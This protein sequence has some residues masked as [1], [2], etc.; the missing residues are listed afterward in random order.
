M[1][2]RLI[3]IFSF[4]ILIMSLIIAPKVEAFDPG[5]ITIE[6][7]TLSITCFRYVDDGIEIIIDGGVKDIIFE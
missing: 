5:D 4:V 6:C 3:G 2:N 7:G 1:K